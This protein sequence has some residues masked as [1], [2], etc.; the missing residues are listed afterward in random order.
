MG[1]SE[2]TNDARDRS[3]DATPRFRAYLIV[4]LIL[5]IPAFLLAWLGIRAGIGVA[6][7]AG[8]CASGLILQGLLQYRRVPWMAWVALSLA[9]V[10]GSSL[11]YSPMKAAWILF[12]VGTLLGARGL[13]TLNRPP[14]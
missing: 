1:S 2:T 12:A 6:A 5:G 14:S 11:F 7:A 10:G 8:L 3:R 4:S 13:F 9:I